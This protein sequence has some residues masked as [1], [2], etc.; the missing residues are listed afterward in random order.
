MSPIIRGVLVGAG[1]TAACLVVLWL[2]LVAGTWLAVETATGSPT[3]GRLFGGLVLAGAA[4][5]LAKGLALL[6][7]DLRQAERRR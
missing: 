2:S 5:V 3:S 7:R 6:A 1:V 4:I